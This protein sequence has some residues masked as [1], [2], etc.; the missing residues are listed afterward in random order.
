SRT[1][2]WAAV[3][4]YRDPTRDEPAERSRGELPTGFL[5]GDLS[6]MAYL[7]QVA[8][9]GEAYQGF[10]LLVCDGQELAYHSNVA[11]A[12]QVVTPGVH[13]L[14][15]HLLDTPWPKV[16]RGRR[17]LEDHLAAPDAP[18]P[19]ALFELLRDTERAPDDQL[20]RTGVSQAWERTLSPIF[21]AAPGYGTRCATVL[22]ADDAGAYDFREQQYPAT[23]AARPASHF[24]VKPAAV[25]S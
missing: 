4:N 21:I 18:Q 11:G 19:D 12:P 20:P 14:S 1:G 16:Q 10:N 23:D 17:A 8:R 9:R 6:P 7:E 3:T 5:R 2:R 25:S 24:R 13:G 15:N 22:V